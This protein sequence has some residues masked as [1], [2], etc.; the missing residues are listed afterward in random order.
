MTA[1]MLEHF[2][3]I[4]RTHENITTR[5][6]KVE[7]AMIEFEMFLSTGKKMLSSLTAAIKANKITHAAIRKSLCGL[8]K[9]RSPPVKSHH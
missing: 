3:T 1:T 7:I 4:R 6:N 8:L 5:Q 9:K 2:E